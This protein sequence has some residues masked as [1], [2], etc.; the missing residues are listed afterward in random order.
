MAKSLESHS[1]AKNAK[2]IRGHDVRKIG[3]PYLYHMIRDKENCGLPVLVDGLTQK[4]CLTYPREL[5]GNWGQIAFHGRMGPFTKWYTGDR[6]NLWVQV[7]SDFR[8]I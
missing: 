5:L 1:I 2:K 7:R 4:M 3:Y 8:P 6:V